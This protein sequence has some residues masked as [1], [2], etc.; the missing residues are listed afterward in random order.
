VKFFAV[1]AAAFGLAWAGVGA[2]TIDRP[3]AVPQLPTFHSLSSLV[4]LNVTVTDGGKFVTGLQPSDFVVYEDGVKQDVQFFESSSVPV[5]LIVL[6]DTS[7]SMADRMDVVH[8]AAIG[9]LNTLR[10]IDRG[11]VVTFADAVDVVQPLTSDRARLTAA[12]GG[13]HAHGS[14]A[15]YTAVYIALRQLGQAASDPH[16]CGV[17]RSWC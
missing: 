11:A 4:S 1:L 14:T 9:F 7:S 5:D 15:L 17:R 8:E 6:I 16:R 13:T 10:P 3:A 12:I 2:Q